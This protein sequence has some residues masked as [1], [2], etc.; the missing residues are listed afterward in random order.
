[1]AERHD[2]DPVSGMPLGHHEWDG[3]RELETRPP[4]WWLLVYV[5]TFV[6]AIG[7]WVVYPAWPT[8]SGFTHGL[9]GW[10]S[11]GAATAQLQ[12]AET[13]QAALNE[14]L[15]LSALDAI[16]KDPELLRFALSGGRAA[17]VNNCAQCHG[18]G[19]QGQP[20]F[21]NLLDDDWLWGGK[22]ADIERT[23]LVGVNS[24]HPD[25]RL[26]QMPAFGAAGILNRQQIDDVAEYVLSLTGR[27]TDRAAVGRGQ[28]VFAQQCASCHGPTGDGGREFGAP[29]LTDA[30][31]LYGGDKATIVQTIA[32]TRRGVM[33]AWDG[34]LSELTIRKLTLYVH[35]LGGGE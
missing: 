12:R 14:R 19:A 23:I 34:R 8:L 6:F 10:S 5:A 9:F 31:W 4:R 11:R 27:Q 26:T 17:F 18:A 21:P 20:G 13:A 25:T 22:L 28:A 1:M 15:R 33:P 30:I 7:Y 24:T 3:I 29:R 35:T 32:Q 16:A 2:V